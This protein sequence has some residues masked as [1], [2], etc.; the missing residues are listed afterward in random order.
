MTTPLE[1]QKQGQ[2]QLVSRAFKAKGGCERESALG[3][4]ETG[5]DLVLSTSASSVQVGR[6]ELLKHLTGRDGRRIGNVELGSGKLLE[7]TGK[8]TSGR[9]P[10]KGTGESI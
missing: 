8:G 10:E 6:V 5:D 3:P 7:H 2:N 4:S 1:D 9:V